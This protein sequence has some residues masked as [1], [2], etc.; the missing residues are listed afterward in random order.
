M[1]R[2]FL[3]LTL[4]LL[5]L[6]QATAAGGDATVFIYH[7]FGDSRY[8]STNVAVER[9]REQ[10][11][12]L[13]ANGYQVISLKEL[14]DKLKNQAPLSPQTVVITIDD[15]YGSVYSKAWPIL[16][17]FGYPFTVFLYVEGVEKGYKNYLT[18][19]QIKEMKDAGVDFQDHSY[20]HHHLVDR[21]E[22]FTESQ[23]R[24]WIRADLASSVTI[25]REKL[26]IRPGYFALP[27]GEYDRLVIEEAKSMGYEAILTQDP[28]SV[29]NY[30]DVYRIPREPILG[31][32]WAELKHFKE[33]LQRVDLPVVEMKPDIVPLTEMPERFGARLVDAGRYERGS[34]GIYVSELGWQQADLDGDFAFITN[35]TPLTRSL[36][37]VMV[38][39][40]EKESGRTAV[41]FWL[42]IKPKE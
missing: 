39:A 40:R 34:F 24:Q 14:V 18:W 1:P 7:H 41:H 3:P 11:S 31:T 5:L 17:E 8:P 19:E 38:S 2:R 12:Y 21:P 10:M 36:N 30:T 9:F 26:G 20:S 33:V 25:M 4:L 22:G 23:Y 15:G 42:L 32:D 35:S 28:G 37:R 6:L 27:Y 13:A 16:K 29:S